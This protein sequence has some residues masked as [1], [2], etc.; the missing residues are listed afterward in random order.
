MTPHSPNLTCQD[1]ERG[2]LQIGVRKDMMLEVHSSLRSLGYVDGGAETVIAALMRTVGNNGALVMP[3]FPVSKPLPL[4]D[5]DRQR[6]LTCKVRLFSET[7]SEPSGM[8]IIPDTFRQ[9]PGVLTGKGMHRVSAWGKDADKNCQGLQNLIENGGYALLI[10]VDIYRLTSM[11]YMEKKLP[12]EI[13]RTYEAPEDV[14]MFYPSDQWYIQ[15][16]RPPDP[17]GRP[18]VQAWYKIQDEAY[19]R[20][21]IRDMVIGKSKCMFFCVND[22]VRIYEQAIETDPFDLFGVQR[23][24]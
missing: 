9:M 10:G 18:P 2:F 16:G 4:S 15:T 1:L 19:G 6:G 22:V 14:L 12:P 7:S 13:Q 3:T 17:T 5:I 11:H 23:Q 8:G 24:S 20:G 21:L